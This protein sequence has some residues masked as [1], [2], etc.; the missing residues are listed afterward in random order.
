[1][2]SVSDY[3][4]AYCALLVFL[5]LFALGHLARMESY[6]RNVKERHLGSASSAK[7]KKGKKA[8]QGDRREMPPAQG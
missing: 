4:L 8:R 2:E 5:L 3:V 6:L 7:R 1:M